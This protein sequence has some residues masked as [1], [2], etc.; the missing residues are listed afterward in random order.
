[1]DEGEIAADSAVGRL[2][3]ADRIDPRLV[4]TLAASGGLLHG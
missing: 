2:V 1:M 4:L 3:E